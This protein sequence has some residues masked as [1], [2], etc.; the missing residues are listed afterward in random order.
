MEIRSV[1]LKKILLFCLSLMGVLLICSFSTAAPLMVEKN[2]FAQDRKPPP[3]ESAASP[4]QPGRPGMPITNIQLDGVMIN[5]SNKK[6]LVR[7]KSPQPGADRK[8]VQ[9][10]FVT[11][12]E[13][14]QIGDF[15]VTRIEPKS[16]QVEKDGQSYT[17]N[18]FAEGKIA[19]PVAAQAPPVNPNPAPGVAE[20]APPIPGQ[21][22]QRANM[23]P[24]PLP[25]TPG[26][27]PQPVNPA[28]N[29]GMDPSQQVQGQ[30]GIPGQ[31][32]SAAV[33]EQP[34]EEDDE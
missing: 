5:G 16:V 15:R 6:A 30:V 26:Q 14:Q 18:L 17:I 22:N 24:R 29:V 10:P 25:F 12:R 34:A 13:G 28:A 11:V 3:P 7:M 20:N 21:P 27:E 1:V 9:S 32:P 4:A 31:D 33:P 8:K 19:S 23:Q 2:L